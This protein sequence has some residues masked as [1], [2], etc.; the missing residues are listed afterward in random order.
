MGI[1]K[2]LAGA[3]SDEVCPVCADPVV[4]ATAIPS[5]R[6]SSRVRRILK[7]LISYSFQKTSHQYC[8]LLLMDVPR[9]QKFVATFFKAVSGRLWRPYTGGHGPSPRTPDRSPIAP[10][11]SGR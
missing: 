11:A 8:T 7:R 4:P 9:Q 3:A 6:K 5:A 10:K 2:P 1:C